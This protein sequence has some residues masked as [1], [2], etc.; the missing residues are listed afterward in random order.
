MRGR[1][2]GTTSSPD[3]TVVGSIHCVCDRPSADGLDA[4]KYGRSYVYIGGNTASRRTARQVM[5]TRGTCVFIRKMYARCVY[6]YTDTSTVKKKT[7]KVTSLLS[8]RPLRRRR[9]RR[10]TGSVAVLPCQGHRT[11]VRRPRPHRPPSQRRCRRR[12]IHRR[13]CTAAA[14]AAA[15]AAVDNDDAIAARV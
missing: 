13:Y 1:T 9:R 4:H 14:P 15:D 6:V 5:R 12:P 3:L 2:V 8:C 10:R 7:T 11:P